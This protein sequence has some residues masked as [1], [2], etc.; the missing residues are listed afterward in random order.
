MLPSLHEQV[1]GALL[2]HRCNQ[3]L[4]QPEVVAILSPATRIEVAHGCCFIVPAR[5]QRL[6]VGQVYLTVDIFLKLNLVGYVLHADANR[7][8]AGL[9]PCWEVWLLAPT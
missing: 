5:P 6:R 9:P 8:G 4:T 1:L 3:L 2:A 7:I